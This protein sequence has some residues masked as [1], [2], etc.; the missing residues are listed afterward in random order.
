MEHPSPLRVGCP[1]LSPFVQASQHSCSNATTPLF[2]LLHLLPPI[3]NLPSLPPDMPH[4]SNPSS[5]RIAVRFPGTESPSRYMQI[6]C[7]H[8]SPAWVSRSI[9]TK[10]PQLF[11]ILEPA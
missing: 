8:Q 10:L 7:C 2:F 1:T 6:L 4:C 5:S 3:L 9:P 11:K